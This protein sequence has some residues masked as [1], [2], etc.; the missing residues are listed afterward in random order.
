M[1]AKFLTSL[2][3]ALAM[4]AA[5]TAPVRADDNGLAYM[6]DI[7]KSGGKSCFSSHTHYG[8]GGGP[9]KKAAQVAAIKSWQDFTAFEYGTDWAWFKKATAKAI[10]CSQSGSGYDCSV[11]ARPCK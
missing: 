5:L 9:T 1:T 10:S 2:A 11:E 3:A 8:T 4:S 6:H 7:S